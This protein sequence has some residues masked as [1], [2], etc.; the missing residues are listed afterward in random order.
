[1][2]HQNR[3]TSFKFKLA[4]VAALFAL[5]PMLA[6]A[7][8]LPGQ[9]SGFASG[10]SHPV[11][12][13]DHILVML[14]V[15]LWAA[16]LGGRSLWLV[17]ATFVSLMTVGGALGM[18]GVHVPMVETGILASVLVLGILIAAAARLPLAV[19]MGV[20]GLFAIFH[21][22]AH[23]TEIPAAA[24]G[25]SYA[26]GFVLATAGLHAC[27]IGLGLAAQKQL[28]ARLPV[29][30]LAGAAIAVAGICLWLF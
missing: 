11:L 17:P 3:H 21:G 28:P 10:L 30:R 22:H 7:H 29:M 18:M 9:V 23:G 25:F 4:A 20:V 5:T 8:H 27:G 19:S 26:M 12:G 16:Q 15:G 6:Q 13:L 24:S 2:N 1:M 14:G